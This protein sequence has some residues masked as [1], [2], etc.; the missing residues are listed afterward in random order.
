[1]YKEIEDQFKKEMSDHK[2]NV[3]YLCG[4]IIIMLIIEIINNIL[5]M[6]PDSIII[7][8]AILELI[9]TLLFYIKNYN[10]YINLK[11]K[12][13]NN[14][15]KV[16]Y[17]DYKNNRELFNIILILKNKNIIQKEDLKHII[18]YYRIKIPR[19]IKQNI[20]NTIIEI[21]L[22]V[23]SFSIIFIGEDKLIDL[24]KAVA[25]LELIIILS[26]I[27]IFYF[28]LG[29]VIKNVFV[30]KDKVYLSLEEKLSFVYINYNN[31]KDIL[32]NKNF[33]KEEAIKLMFTKIE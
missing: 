13:F 1:M 25:N 12:L 10:K 32:L 15:T 33:N 16:R 28:S 3:W 26:I 8:T 7:A 14:Q 4:S 29:K 24:N 21:L 27:I 18:E 22:G 30:T 2:F 19:N 9:S 17:S 11:N 23:L 6:N 20:F 5:K 31:F